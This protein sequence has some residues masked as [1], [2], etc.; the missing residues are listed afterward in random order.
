MSSHLASAGGPCATI[1][2]R[3]VMKPWLVQHKAHYFDKT[4]ARE[5]LTG[6]FI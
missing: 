1:L 2:T 4:V 5:K 6:F 3:D